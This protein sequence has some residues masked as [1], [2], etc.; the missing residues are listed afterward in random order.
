MTEMATTDIGTMS[1][2]FLSNPK[3]SARFSSTP[4]IAAIPPIQLDLAVAT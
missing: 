2:F 3:Q 4:A 1:L